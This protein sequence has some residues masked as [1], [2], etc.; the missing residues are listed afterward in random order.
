MK[1]L[2]IVFAILAVSMSLVVAFGQGEA[3]DE[4]QTL[5]YIVHLDEGEHRRDIDFGVIASTSTTS[6][7][8]TSTSPTSP[9]STTTT[10]TTVAPSPTLTTVP[11]GTV[12]TS[13]T[14]APVVPIPT[15]ETPTTDT[16]SPNLRNRTVLALTLISLLSYWLWRRRPR[17]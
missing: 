13:T 6:S 3:H 2:V 16:P 7:S 8:T 5:T 9:S 4:G 12:T 10:A 11:L 1:W 17:E 15:T 14:Q